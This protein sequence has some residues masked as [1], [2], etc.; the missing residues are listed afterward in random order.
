MNQRGVFWVK[1]AALWSGAII[2]VGS[3]LTYLFG[4]VTWIETR[5][6]VTQVEVCKTDCQKRIDETATKVR[7][8]LT[9]AKKTMA[10]RLNKTDE[11]I[12]TIQNDIGNVKAN[13][14]LLIGAQGLRPVR[15]KDDR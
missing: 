3:V 9:E 10:N 13:L 15:Q 7:G 4:G 5:A 1:H 2:G 14:Y 6:S 8:E 12:G 11:S